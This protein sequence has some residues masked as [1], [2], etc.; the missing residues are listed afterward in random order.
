[1]A[2][3][4][5][6]AIPLLP[7]AAGRALAHPLGNFTINRFSGIELTGSQLTV[8]YVVDMA[9]IPTFNE[10]ALVDSDGD[11]EV[12]ANEERT[13]LAQ[14]TDGYAQQIS[15]TVAGEPL[16][17]ATV[18][19]ALTVGPGQAG[20]RTL[21]V[22]AVFQAALPV[23]TTRSDLEYRDGNFEGRPGWQ[24]V[25][26]YAGGGAEVISADV[27]STSLSDALRA[28]PEDA[29][30]SPPSQATAIVS[31]EATPGSGGV[32]SVTLS[33]PDSAPR[34]LAGA[35]FARLITADRLSAAVVAF[36]L[37]AAMGFG[38]MHA[39]GPG[40]GKTVVAA[41]LV[42]SRGTARH[43]VF[44]G[45]TVTLTHTIS[46]FALGGVTLWASQYVVPERLYPWLTLISG[47]T[48]VG[49]GLLLF[50]T[51]LRRTSALHWL[52]TRLGIHHHHH[53]AGA[54]HGHNEAEH[55]HSHLPP[56]ADGSRVTW[57]SLLA[58][59]VSGGLL[60]CPSALVV[61]LGAISL[62]RAGFGMLLIV[63]FS[64]GLAGVLT[65]IGLALVWS[66]R[67][68]A[69]F[70]S[71][72]VVDRV[73]VLGRPLVRRLVTQAVPVAS[74]LGVAVAGTILTLG[75][76]GDPTLAI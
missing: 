65:G 32:S 51:R 55:V 34:P 10:F 15:A 17:L 60:P 72:G 53:P 31:F 75:A 52:Q 71:G 69:R 49:L 14:A 62:H 36:S 68:A 73:P 37:L 19:S 5:A 43:A 8:H 50:V 26:V 22:D 35:A 46:V 27:P 40:H 2:L 76:L 74:A 48:V 56:G 7:Q 16:D 1:L 13:Y 64:L 24:E 44:L 11:G 58:L 9:E 29:L 28:Y 54:G 25:I 66:R 23:G 41:Y 38:A 45:A 59:G 4:A 6:L 18:S 67:L 42:G 3:L 63:A 33:A 47:L 70:G 39:L 20:L 57:R 12:S 30:Q 61:L 21:R